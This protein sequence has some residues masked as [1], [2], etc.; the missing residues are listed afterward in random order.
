MQ[1]LV[2]N[3]I[4]TYTAESFRCGV[5]AGSG[6][7]LQRDVAGDRERDQASTHREQREREDYFS[8]IWRAAETRSAAGKTTFLNDNEPNRA[9]HPESIRA[10]PWTGGAR[11]QCSPSPDGTLVACY[12]FNKDSDRP[13]QTV[14]V[15]FGT[16]EPVRTFYDFHRGH[17]RW[18]ADSK[19]LTY[20]DVKDF[21][22]V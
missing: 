2:T 13:W 6:E 3:A 11:A 15:P 12:I 17:C 21:Y 16:N 1:L 9:N 8:H 5:F 14:V 7:Y 4:F 22:N 18:T 19:S 20:I 10:N